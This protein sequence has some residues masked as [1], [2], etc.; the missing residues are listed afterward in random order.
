VPATIA[1]DGAPELDVQVQNQ[2]DSEETGVT[3]SVTVNGGNTIEKQISTI[4]P[5]ETQTVTIPLTPAP[6]GQTTIDVE[7]QPVPGEQVSDNNSA[8]YDVTFE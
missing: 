1:A 6:T 4:A 8:S 7:V 5:G 3:V 2:G